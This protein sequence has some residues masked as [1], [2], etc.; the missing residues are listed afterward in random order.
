MLRDKGARILAKLA[1]HIVGFTFNGSPQV[2]RRSIRTILNSVH[3]DVWPC[4]RRVALTFDCH[5]RCRHLWW[6]VAFLAV[7]FASAEF[8]NALLTKITDIAALENAT[9]TVLIQSMWKAL[10]K[11][12]CKETSYGGDLLQRSSK[13]V[14]HPSSFGKS[15]L[16]NF[17]AKYSHKIPSRDV[18]ESL[19]KIQQKR[20]LQGCLS[21]NL[22][23]RSL[24]RS[25]SRSPRKIGVQGLYIQQMP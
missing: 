18:N 2:E 7:F 17:F 10:S 1:N 19:G 16:H 6:Q 11:L 24:R 4:T 21:K 20:S 25:R 3:F 12:S 23:A 22:Y 5:V 13:R 15:S 14:F 8:M 9:R